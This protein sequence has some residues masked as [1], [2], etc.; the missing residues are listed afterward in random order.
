MA[1]YGWS[2][3]LVH[4]IRKGTAM[5][6]GVTRWSLAA[7]LTLGLL[8]VYLAAR[9]PH[10]FW[11]ATTSRRVPQPVSVAPQTPNPAIQARVMGDFHFKRGNWDEAIAAYKAA[12]QLDPTNREVPQKLKDAIQGCK[13]EK[14]ILGGDFRCGAPPPAPKSATQA[15]VMGDLQFE[16]GEYD[17][18]IDSYKK[19]L[20]LAPSNAE[21]QNRL[22][23]AMKACQKDRVTLPVPFTCGARNPLVK[24]IPPG[25][26]ARWDGHVDYGRLVPANYLEISLEP[27]GS[28]SVPPSSNAPPMAVV[29]IAIHIDT[30]G[31]V[32]PAEVA[33]DENGLAPQVLEA[34][35]AWKF[36]PPTLRGIPVGV[37]TQAIV[38]F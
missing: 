5:L 34:A 15:R 25:P 38:V 14:R 8:L 17:E 9:R 24:L 2:G 12:L 13:L 35:K 29:V 4:R 32:T 20:K 6:Q 19:G 33:F 16:R 28:L 26:P 31:D 36:H 11:P 1:R 23:T 10:S 21:L 3:K 18:A 37:S 27:V 30:S 22:D 7:I